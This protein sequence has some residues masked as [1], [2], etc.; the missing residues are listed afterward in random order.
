MTEQ[1]LQFKIVTNF[2]NLYPEQRGMLIEI[3]N[4]TNKGAFRKG[5]GLVKGAADLIF[6]SPSGVVFT[7]ELKAPGARHNVKHLR[8]QLEWAKKI[9]SKALSKAFF[10]FDLKQFFTII[11]AIL[12]H[13]KFIYSLESDLTLGYIE[14]LIKDKKDSQAVKIDYNHDKNKSTN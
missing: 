12:K 6:I 2:H 5:M 8:E 7:F 13:N 3:N 9:N 10:I 4:S 1:Q 11:I 14:D